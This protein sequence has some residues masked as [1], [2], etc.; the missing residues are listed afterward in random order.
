GLFD[1]VYIIKF[2]PGKQ[3][4][5]YLFFLSIGII[6]KGELLYFMLSTHMTVSCCRTIDRIAQFETCLNSIRAHIT[7]LTNLL[8][9]STISH[10]DLSSTFCIYKNT[11]RLG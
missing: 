8:C 9:N 5:S 10:V 4:Y 11:H 6:N 3:F 7:Y 1:F 2:L